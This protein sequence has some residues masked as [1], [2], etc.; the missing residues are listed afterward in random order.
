MCNSP[1][2]CELEAI[3]QGCH[4]TTL[5]GNTA[6]ENASAIDAPAPAKKRGWLPLLTVL[7]LISYAL[8]TML[9]VEQG[10]TIESQRALIRELF[11]DSTELTSMKLKAQQAAAAQQQTPAKKQG[12]NPSSQTEA[13]KK[14]APSTQAV[15]QN[16]AQKSQPQF[17]TPSRPASDISDVRRELI[18]I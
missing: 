6:L 5:F 17:Q 2:A 10:A 1:S 18:T 13:P 16:R 8:M 14:Q 15:P 11:R 7:F 12:Q 9:I 4:L 3:H